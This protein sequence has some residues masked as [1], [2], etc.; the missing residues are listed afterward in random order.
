VDILLG[1]S[2]IKLFL[3]ARLQAIKEWVF[4]TVQAADYGSVIETDRIVL[5]DTAEALQNDEEV[6]K[7]Y[8]S[9]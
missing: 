9:A 3:V 8:I 1:K 4:L 5:K 2:D 7:A 6:K